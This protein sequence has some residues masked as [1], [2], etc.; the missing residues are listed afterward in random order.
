MTKQVALVTGALV[1]IGKAIAERLANDGFFVVGTATTDNGAT[2]IADYLG[3]NGTGLKLEM[4]ECRI[5][6]RNR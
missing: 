1:G 5:G 6:Y 3:E 2:A 4:F